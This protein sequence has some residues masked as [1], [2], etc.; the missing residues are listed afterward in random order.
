[1]MKPAKG[2]SCLCGAVQFEISGKFES[3]FLCHCK[4]C[5]K[6]TGS[7]YAANLFSSTATLNWISSLD[8]IR[9][10]RIP[11]TRHEKSFCTQCGSAV[12]SVQSEG[13]MVVVP[14]GSMDSMIDIQPSAHIC[15]AS[16]AEWDGLCEEIP[17]VDELPG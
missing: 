3:F 4:R 6:D 16:R 12:P 13:S 1:M 5:R 14:A 9:T 8:S 15:Y 17:R 2:G 10:Y 11:G 7:A